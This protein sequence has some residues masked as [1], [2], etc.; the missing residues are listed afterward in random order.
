MSFGGPWIWRLTS[1]FSPRNDLPLCHHAPCI[2]SPITDLAVMLTILI[3]VYLNCQ[4]RNCLLYFE[5]TS[6]MCISGGFKEKGPC[7]QFTFQWRKISMHETLNKFQWFQKVNSKKCCLTPPV[8]PLAGP[9][10]NC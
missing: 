9:L 5:I 1:M 6:R 8:M 3:V 7:Q 2:C 10:L 4:Y